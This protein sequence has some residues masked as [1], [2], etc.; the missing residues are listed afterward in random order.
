LWQRIEPLLPPP[1]PRRFRYPGRK[2]LDRRN[3]PTLISDAFRDHHIDSYIAALSA[4]NAPVP[5]EVAAA[6]VSQAA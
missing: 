4:P 5:A 1:K 3:L 2:P 6:P